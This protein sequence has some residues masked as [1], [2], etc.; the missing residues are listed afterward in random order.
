[1]N[2]SRNQRLALEFLQEHRG[3]AFDFEQLKKKLRIPEN[4]RL[5]LREM[6][7]EA[8]LIERE[9]RRNGGRNRYFYW[10]T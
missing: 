7:E 2:L 10:C 1:M 3:L 8:G 6:A 4:H 9:K 5:Q